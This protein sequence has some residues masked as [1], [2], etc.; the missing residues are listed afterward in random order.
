M[1]TDRF[2]FSRG[3]AGEIKPRREFVFVLALPPRGLSPNA[4]I[5]RY[6]KIS[7][8]QRRTST[9]QELIHGYRTAAWA[10]AVQVTRNSKPRW[11]CAR[12]TAT[13][14]FRDCRRRDIRNYE[15]ML[16]PAY[17]GFVDAGVIT[18]DRSGVLMH[19]ETEFK[20]DRICPRVE[21]IIERLADK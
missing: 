19:G 13:F 4:R 20:V 11:Q 14:F 21:I 1:K 8:R 3:K 9:Q 7:R 2:D 5:P 15:A 17:D 16:K 18:D 12:A 10:I 6:S